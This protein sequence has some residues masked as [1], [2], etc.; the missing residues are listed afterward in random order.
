MRRRAPLFHL[1]T[2]AAL[3][4][5]PS[6]ARAEEPARLVPD[7]IAVR[8]VTPE[9]GGVARPAF[10]TARQVAFFTR[11]EALFEQIPIESAGEYPER[12]V[13]SAIDRI[14]ARS[15]LA[16]LM[17]QRGSEP[18][19]LPKL[20]ADAREELA[21]RLGANGN[22][23]LEEAMKREGIDAAELQAFLRDQVRAI[24]YIDRAITPI[25]SV[26]EESLREAFRGATHP[27]RHIKSFDDARPL[28]KRWLVTE[29]LRAA[30]LEFLQGARSRIRIVA[31]APP[32]VAAPA[33]T[34]PAPGA[35][36]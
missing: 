36:R 25:I 30:E 2:L 1:L 13:R 14:I 11:L 34:K 18:P 6:S 29:R 9:T 15:M 4:A 35:A 33:P 3:A 16:K 10:L 8:Y 28:L 17:I 22:A 5:W 20:A 12:Y 19:E 7:H 21:T 26:T 27:F 32:A 23:A 31:V 24:S